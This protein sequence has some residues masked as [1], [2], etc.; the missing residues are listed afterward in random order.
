MNSGKRFQAG[1]NYGLKKLPET[2]R[3]TSE[4][5]I[6]AYEINIL[7]K[8]LQKIIFKKLNLNKRG[9]N[10]NPVCSICEKE[11]ESVTHVFL[12]CD[13]SKQVWGKWVGCPTN[14]TANQLDF[15]DIALQILHNGAATD[16]ERFFVTSWVIWYNRNQ[17]VFEDVCHSPDQVWCSAISIS[18]GFREAAALCGNSQSDEASRWEAPPVGVYKVNVDGAASGDGRSTGIGVVIRNSMGEP[19]AALCKPLPRQFSSLE[20]EI[21]AVEHGILLAK[22]MELSNVI[23]ESDALTVVQDILSKEFNGS[24]GHLYQGICSLLESFC[25]WKSVT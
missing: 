12:Q 8:Q 16:L 18:S 13:L 2:K 6:Q 11:A 19:I 4:G 20:T 22:E 17:K 14:L 3:R 9:V 21:F 10:I 1:T 23:L 7:S 15:T 24:L 25:S 5:F